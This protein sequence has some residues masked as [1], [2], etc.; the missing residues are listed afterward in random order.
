MLKKEAHEEEV[1]LDWDE[2]QDLW[3]AGLPKNQLTEKKKI[4]GFMVELSEEEITKDGR[5]EEE[6]TLDW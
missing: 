6:L 3:T 1:A 2:F 4:E 5:P